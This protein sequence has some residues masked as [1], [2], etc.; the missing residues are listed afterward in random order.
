MPKQNNIFSKKLKLIKAISPVLGISLFMFG[1]LKFVNPFKTWYETQILKS[2][3]DQSHYWLGIVGE[4]S[5]GLLLIFTWIF[6]SKLS[7]KQIS[8]SI[9]SSSVLIIAMMIMASYVHLN[10]DVPASVLPLKIKPPI[11][12]LTFLLLAALNIFLRRKTY[13]RL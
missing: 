13:N 1:V 3:L 4:I 11:I 6:W 12:P 10:P 7:S 5:I 2:G 8:I 9:I